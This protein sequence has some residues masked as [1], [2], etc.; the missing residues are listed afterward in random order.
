MHLY[1][2]NVVGEPLTEERKKQLITS[3]GYNEEKH[4]AMD[5]GAK[6]P[7]R[8]YQKSESSAGSA[9][10]NKH[11]GKQWVETKAG[12]ENHREAGGVAA[13][14]QRYGQGG[15][16]PDQR[17]LDGG[18]EAHPCRGVGIPKHLILGG[19]RDRSDRD[20]IEKGRA[21]LHAPPMH[22]P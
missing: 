14:P 19:W 17:L 8:M 12:Q 5:A 22:R 16:G 11:F 6:T 7:V 15:Q 2:H 21:R 1:L 3:Y 4:H 13:P 20:D 9:S 10:K 18:G